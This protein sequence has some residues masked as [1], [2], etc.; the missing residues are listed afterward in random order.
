MNLAELGEAFRRAR[1][2]ANLTQQQVADISG[3]T[4]GRISM[5]ETGTLPEIGAVKML[6]LFDAVGLELSARRPGHQRTL[7]DV[8][9]EPADSEGVP[10]RQ[11]VRTNAMQRLKASEG[12][13]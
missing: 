2:A 7:D 9:S 5:F 6:S 8:L 10:M 12:K 3:V 1:M 4:R 13:P 11:R